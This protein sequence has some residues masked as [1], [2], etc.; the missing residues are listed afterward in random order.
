MADITYTVVRGDTLGDIAKRFNTSVSALAALNNITDPNYIVVG[1][2]LKI[3]GTPTTESVNTTSK[4]VITMFGLQ[5]NTDRTVYAAWKWDKSNTKNYEVKWEYATGDGMWFIG[6]TSTVEYKQSTYSAPSNAT[7]VQFRVKP[8]SET[9]TINNKETNYW[10]AGWSTAK[11]YDFA[12]NPP[13]KPSTPTV[14]IEGLTLTA[15]LDNIDVNGKSIQFQVVKDNSTIFKTGTIDIVTSHVTYSCSV[16]AGSEYKV[17]CRAIRDKLYSDWSEYSNSI[18]T[19]PSAPTGITKCKASSET[20]VYLEWPAVKN[21]KSYD[22]EYTKKKKYFDGSDQVDTINNIETTHYEKTGLDTGEEYFFRVRAVNDN[23]HSAWTSIKSTIIGKTPTSPTTWSST[24]TAITGETL[25]LYWV[26]NAEDGSNQTFAE[27]ELYID[28]IK[29][30]Y[31]LSDNNVENDTIKY[32]ALTEEEKEKGKTNSC[33]VKTSSYGEGVKIQW[34]VRTAGITKEYGD[35]SIQRTIDIYAPPTLELSITNSDGEAFDILETFPFY[36]S[37]LA[38]PNTQVPI[39][40][41]LSVIANEMYDTV[42]DVGNEKTVSAGE[43]VYSKYFDITD[44]LLVEMSAGNVD[45]ENNIEYTIKCLVSMNSGLTA[46]SSSTFTVA[47]TDM[48]YEPN[49]EIGIDSETISAFI[50]PH[51]TNENNEL[52]PNVVLSV[53]RREFDGSFTELAKNLVNS[54]ELFITDPHPSLDYARYRVVAKTT[55]TG[56][57]S[58]CDIPGYPVGESAIIIQW[59]E[60]WTS[61]DTTNEDE[62]SERPWTGSML[63]LPYNVD[64]SDSTKPDVALVEYIGRKN[65]VSYYGTQLGETS[66]WNVTIPKSDKETIYALRRLA[67]W[68][69]DVYVREPS[70]TGYWAHIT[71]SFSQKHCE[72]TIPVSLDITRVEGGV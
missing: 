9:R 60:E 59:D 2:V 12:N 10:T 22:I 69:G 13:T 68:M 18:G 21:A 20:S 33:E 23:G 35:W 71:V 37:A 39:G 46:E 28:G 43:E 63:K 29:K 36:V 6:N 44:S 14:E 54:N 53:F 57:V 4:A 47:W 32:T 16:S 34:R 31:T 15:T 30:T 26:H 58:Y 27:L 70:G 65:P 45:L 50:R 40:Y 25:N 3:S 52:I 19:Q 1:Q 48:E 17:R 41:H 11:T 66:T 62:L 55:D 5:S 49:A 51:C 7:S 38:G 67:K 56:S 72:V 64:V 42:D 24:T 61:F 8:I